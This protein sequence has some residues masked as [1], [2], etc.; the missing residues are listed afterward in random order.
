MA[1]TA[2][3]SSWLFIKS[4]TSRKILSR[5]SIGLTKLSGSFSSVVSDLRNEVLEIRRSTKPHEITRNV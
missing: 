1:Q 2:M 4:T 3:L 5:S